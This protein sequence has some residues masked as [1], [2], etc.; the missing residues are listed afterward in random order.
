MDAAKKL[1]NARPENSRMAHECPSSRDLSL[2]YFVVTINAPLL[3]LLGLERDARSMVKFLR[4]AANE[5]ARPPRRGRRCR[6]QS[7]KSLGSKSFFCVLYFFSN[8]C[9]PVSS[10]V[11]ALL[12]LFVW[13]AAV[14]TRQMVECLEGFDRAQK[15]ES[16]GGAA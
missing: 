15:Q 8:I 14:Y 9:D 2:A 5:S 10:L 13:L 4:Q 7:C 11:F 6:R 3:L 16:T 12:H 1:H